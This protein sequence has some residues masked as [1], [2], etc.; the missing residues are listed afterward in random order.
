MQAILRGDAA[1]PIGTSLGSFVRDSSVDVAND[2]T[3]I[4]IAGSN[5]IG[6]RTARPPAVATMPPYN[7]AATLSA[8]PSSAAANRNSSGS[9]ACNAS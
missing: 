2:G 4:T 6:T 8:W 3:H 7:D 1:S 9:A 5:D